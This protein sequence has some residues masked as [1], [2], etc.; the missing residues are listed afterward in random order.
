MCGSATQAR[1]H[2]CHLP[3]STLLFRPPASCCG[4]RLHIMH[5]VLVANGSHLRVAWCIAPVVDITP[6]VRAALQHGS[7]A[8]SRPSAGT[9]HEPDLMP[10][11]SCRAC[12]APALPIC[13]NHPPAKPGGLLCL[14]SLAGWRVDR[15]MVASCSRMFKCYAAYHLLQYMVIQGENR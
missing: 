5:T 11:W 10:A 3:A 12:N 9:A 1:C 6:V 7:C 15:S 2:R 4:A 13:C 14:A 8:W